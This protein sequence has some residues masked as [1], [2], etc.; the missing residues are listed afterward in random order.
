MASPLSIAHVGTISYGIYLL[1]MQ[2]IMLVERLFAG[3]GLDRLGPRFVVG[4][5][6]SIVLADLSYRFFETPFLEMKHRFAGAG[7]PAES[8]LDSPDQPDAFAGDRRRS[9][10]RSTAG[11]I[12]GSGS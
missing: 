1:H 8:A 10:L 5:T 6:G 7:Q 2:V 4:L 11:S 3:G 12:S 9:G